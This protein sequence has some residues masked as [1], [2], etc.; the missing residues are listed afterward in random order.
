[1]LALVTVVSA[2]ACASASQRRADC[3]PVPAEIAMTAGTM[4]YR[5]CNVDRGASIGPRAQRV[6]YQPSRGATCGSAT[7]EFVV[8]STGKPMLVT[9]RVVKTTDDALAAAM[10]KGLASQTFKPATRD[11]HPVAVLTTW[12]SEYATFVIGRAGGP[13]PPP[14]PKC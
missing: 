7:I 14:S 4:V 10:V 3:L 2:L 5:D 13:P 9:A 8:D 11:G 6:D 12:K 1:M